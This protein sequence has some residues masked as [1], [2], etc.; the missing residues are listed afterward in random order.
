MNIYLE[1]LIIAASRKKKRK[2]KVKS[3][4]PA[5]GGSDEL[6]LFK[7]YCRK[8]G[9][10]GFAVCTSG[11]NFCRNRGEILSYVRKKKS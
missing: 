2:G 8:I 7:K 4:K 3:L 9:P 10:S 6:S 11:S 5:H 1:S